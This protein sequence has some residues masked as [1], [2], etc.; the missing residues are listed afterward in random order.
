MTLTVSQI[1]KHPILQKVFG[2]TR[3][4][5]MRP[6]TFRQT[7]AKHAKQILEVLKNSDNCFLIIH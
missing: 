3:A 2:Q 4:K 1:P 5:G 7:H 6:N